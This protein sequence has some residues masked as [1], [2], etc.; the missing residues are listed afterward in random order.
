MRS[1]KW[2]IFLDAISEI[3][4]RV[5]TNR[6]GHLEVPISAY[7]YIYRGQILSP[8]DN[9]DK[10]VKNPQKKLDFFLQ[11]ALTFLFLRVRLSDS[12]RFPIRSET[13]VSEH[14]PVNF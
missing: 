14:L 4:I 8:I 2:S 10:M 6:F 1:P 7:V 5:F 11:N 3:S 13:L 9:S 12:E